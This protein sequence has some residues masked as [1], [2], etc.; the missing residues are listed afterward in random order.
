MREKRSEVEDDADADRG[1]WEIG[2][3]LDEHGCN[4]ALP[5]SEIV[6]TRDAEELER[7]R[8]SWR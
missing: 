8:C 6:M 4:T 1:C 5:E 3:I 2:A 7:S